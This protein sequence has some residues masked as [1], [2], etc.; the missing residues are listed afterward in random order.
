MITLLFCMRAGLYYGAEAHLVTSITM[1][2][3]AKLTVF[4]ATLSQW[5]SSA[6]LHRHLCSPGHGC[7]HSYGIQCDRP[8]V[9]VCCASVQEPQWVLRR[10]LQ[11]LVMQ[12][13]QC[14]DLTLLQVSGWIC[15]A[16]RPTLCMLSCSPMWTT[17]MA[18]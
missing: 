12:A 16:T 17:A 10:Y 8:R 14:L 4:G 1:N 9:Y 6:D 13:G 11:L 2:G 3:T 18:L 15:Q 7:R 5:S